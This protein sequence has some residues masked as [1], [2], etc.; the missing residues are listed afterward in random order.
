MKIL[1]KFGL[2]LL[3]ILIFSCSDDNST[4]VIPPEEEQPEPEQPE[5]E[6]SD[7]T[8][9]VPAHDF[10]MGGLFS[11]QKDLRNGVNAASGGTAST[12]YYNLPLFEAKEFSATDEEWWDNLVE[13]FVYSGLDYVAANCR[14]RLPRADT[15]SRYELDHGDPTRIKD[16][17]A[18]MERRGVEDL[19]IAIFDDCPAS[20][21]AARNFDLYGKYSS[22][23]SYSQQEELGLTDAE[24]VYP[25]DDL[26]DIYK[27]IWDYNIKLAFENFYGENAE[28]NKYLFRFNGKPVLYLWSVNGFLNVTYKA[29][30]GERP[31]CTGKLKVIL[32][33]IRADFNATFGE[34]VFICVDKAFSDRDMY[35]D[36]TVVDARN[37]WFVASEQTTNRYSYSL[38]GY[39][40]V[41]TGVAVPAFLTN[42]KS[43]T[44]MFFDAEHG[45]RLIDALDYMVKYEADL[46]LLEGFT[47]MAENAAY[48]RS[49]DTKFYDFPNQ[50]LNILR[51]YSSKNAY[52]ASFRVEAEACDFYEDL[53]SGNSGNQYRKGDLDVKKC[54]DGF[55]GWCVTDTESGES[56]R[57]VELPFSAGES[58]VKLRYASQED[59]QIRFDIDG[60]EG[61]TVDLPATGGSWNEIDAATVNFEEKGWREVVLNIVSGNVDLNCFTIVLQ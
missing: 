58:I 11:F 9:D 56:L 52:P 3:S 7:P 40:N 33:K 51:K 14:G 37:R 28:N 6:P 43:G 32:D 44:R 31:D 48:W 30:G 50:R 19:K 17:I 25:L 21:A 61:N 47:D 13:E 23:L 29:L 27:Y 46:L 8:N 57:W 15:E 12:T 1:T 53:S 41:R 26:D 60:V 16:L 49:T 24:L 39:N 22:V 35:V 55:N 18:A 54:V 59:G 5:P 45:Q 20:W 34:D 36:A 2:I 4:S 10:L 42:D 38:E